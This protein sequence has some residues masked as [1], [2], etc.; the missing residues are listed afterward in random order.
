MDAYGIDLKGSS[1]NGN[2]RERGVQRISNMNVYTVRPSNYEEMREKMNTKVF[3]KSKQSFKDEENITNNFP[4]FLLATHHYIDRFLEL[5][6]LVIYHIIEFYPDLL[7]KKGETI[8]HVKFFCYG[9]PNY[10]FVKNIVSSM[11][12][13]TRNS[14]ESFSDFTGTF[15]RFLHKMDVHYTVNVKEFLEKE[16]PL[17]A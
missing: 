1:R 3:P 11:T 2:I 9:F 10:E 12:N 7:F 6:K 8:G 16:R 14:M 17:Q 15:M 5:K 13:K 4:D